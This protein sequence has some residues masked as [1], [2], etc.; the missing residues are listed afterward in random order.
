MENKLSFNLRILALLLTL[1]FVLGTLASLSV[2]PV[3]AEETPGEGGEGEEVTDPDDSESGGVMTIADTIAAYLTKPFESKEE[4]LATMQLKLSKGDYELYCES[5]TG[6]VA[7]KNVVTG[8]ILTTNPYDV[9]TV[10][11]DTVKGNLLSQVVLSFQDLEN[12]NATRTFYSYT[13]AA[14]SGQIKVRNVK[15]GVRIEYILGKIASKK[16]MPY[17][18]EASRFEKM[19]LSNITEQYKLGKTI[20]FYDRKDLNGQT[21]QAVIQELE[22]NYPCVKNSYQ[23]LGI[24]PM[25]DRT[26]KD[27]AT[28][29]TVFVTE[30]V[31]HTGKTV[32]HRYKMSD[33][34]VIYTI[35]NVVV[36]SEKMSNTME[37]YVK[38]FCPDYSYEQRDYDVET[39]GYVGDDSASANFRLALEYVVTDNGFEVSLPANSVRYD[40]TRYR[41]NYINI[42]PYIGASSSEVPGYTFIPDGSG[43]IIRNE[44]IAKEGLGYTVSGQLYGA[45]F[46]YHKISYNGKSEV[47][48]MPVFGVVEGTGNKTKIGEEIVY[49]TT[50][51]PDVLFVDENG[52]YV[53]VEWTV[54]EDEIE[55]VIDEYGDH[56]KWVLIERPDREVEPV[57]DTAG[58]VTYYV[59]DE[60][61][62]HEALSIPIYDYDITGAEGYF[63]IIKEGDSL[64]TLTSNHGGNVLHKYNSVYPACYPESSD[65]YNL[66]D[67]ISVGQDTAWTVVSERKFTGSFKIEY[68]LISS[69]EGSKYDASYM[70]MAAAYRDYLMGNGTLKKLENVSNS[71]PLYI[72]SFGMMKTKGVIATIPVMLDTALTSFDD[73]EEMYKRL[74]EKNIT[75][76]NFRLTG[77]N[78]GGLQ[79]PSPIT[80]VKFERVLGGNKGYKEMLERAKGRYGVYPDFDFANV[81]GGL[82]FDGYSNNKHAV[83]TIDDRYSRKRAYDATYQSFQYM[84]AVCTSPSFYQYF[85]QKFEKKIDKLGVSGLSFSTLGTD[86]NSD[87]DED[88]PYNREDNKEFT[89]ELLNDLNEKY[90]DIMIDGGNAYTWGYVNHI[91]NASLDGSRYMRASQS[92]PFLGLV[93]HGSVNIA[94]KPTNMQGDIEY[95]ILKIIE[96]GASPY[97]TLSYENT[98]K[99]KE[100]YRIAKYYSVDYNIWEDDLVKIYNIINDALFD[101]QDSL[102]VDHHFLFGTR[103]FSPEDKAHYD[104]E[105]QAAQEAYLE[106][107]NAALIKA[108]KKAIRKGDITVPDDYNYGTGED[109]KVIAPSGF[110]MEK[111]KFMDFDEYYESGLSLEVDDYTIVYEKYENG[112]Q[113]IINFNSFSVQVEVNGKTYV[114]NDYGFIKLDSAGNELINY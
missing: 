24:T 68:F 28:G 21:V 71:I 103:V 65:T 10:S 84:G 38:E 79:N 76:V 98:A 35:T 102:I 46:A 2:L 58:K 20:S 57:T 60:N 51:D 26:E 41:L 66:A 67:S 85:L 91:L 94:G 63:A 47:M 42:L 114:L 97:Y 11:S 72:E 4:K 56:V 59:L 44:D 87:F 13:D 52:E 73:V 22:L 83:R 100:S 34:F 89:V 49:K 25:Y 43:T 92:V 62:D 81:S 12:N 110:D 106:E 32:T 69:Q 112:T 61:G 23:K 15:N 17:W 48:R 108:I 40:R 14:T 30:Y 70:G 1:M 64:I 90:K 82:L 9:Y 77:V 74:S 93:L 109:G 86:L 45:D 111:F 5:H 29:E 95:E 8:Q 54:T 75:N 107:Y 55:E 53:P 19:I 50:E 18:I 16:L 37:G 3:F 105:L 27:P 101:V 7:V 31:D 104:S 36:A 113:M 39:T 99:L 6:E 33:N 88:E 96:N 80:Y 78:E